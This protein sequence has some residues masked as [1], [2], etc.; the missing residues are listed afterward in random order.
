MILKNSILVFMMWLAVSPA[1]AATDS[2]PIRGRVIDRLSRRPVSFAAVVIAG[3][4]N[5]GASTDSAGLFLIEHVQPGI[6]RLNVSSLGY[7]STVT[8]EYLVSAATPF[9]EIELEEDASQLEAVTVTPSPFRR[10]AESPVS[11]KVIG[12]REIEKSPGSNRDI[13]RIVRSYPGVSFSP[14]GYR[15]DLIVRGGGPSENRFFMDG[16]EIPNINHFATQG[17]SGG[18][19]S[20]VN[21]DLVREINLY[22]GSFPANRAGALSSVLD[23]KLRDGDPKRQTFKATLGA[24]EV[25]ISGSGHI[26][27]KTTYL[28]SLR[29]SY[30]QFLFKLLGLPFLPNYIDGQ[31]KIKTR[32]SE[33][34]EL[35][36]LGLT[37]IDNMRLNTDEKGEEAE[38]LLSYLPR[39]K[40]E[41]FTV[42]ASYRHYAGRHV[43]T[44]TLSHT[45]LNNRNVKYRDNDES[46]EDNLI[47][48]LRAVEQKTTLR[49]ENRSYVGR[50]TLREGV[51]LNYSHY[52]NQTLQRLYTQQAGLSDYRTLLGTVGWGAFV[53]ADYASANKRLTA[54]AGLRADGCDYSG[55]TARF[56]HQLSPRA[57]VSYALSDGW[58]VSGSAGL[59]YQLPPYTA[60]G[61]KNSAGQLVNRDLKYMRVAETSGGFAWRLRDRLIVSLEGFYKFYNDIPL[62]LAD[63][64]PLTCKGNDYGTVGDERLVSTAEGRAYGLEAMVQW[65]I[66]GK[67]NV[68]GSATVYRSEYRNDRRSPYIASA[69]DNRFVLNLSGTYDLPRSW[70]IGAKV[71]AIGG[72]PYTP[73]D[74]EKSSLKVAWDAQGRP[75]YDY[76]RYNSGRLSAFAQLDLRVDKTFYFKNCMLGLYIDLQNVTGSK[77]RQP[78]VLMSTGIVENPSAPVADQRYKMKYIKQ[79]SGTLV[80]TLGVTVEF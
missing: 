27:E 59:Y 60:L 74:V 54:S 33:T 2:Y 42:G 16:I 45:Y 43:Q 76:D 39:L 4:E 20:I 50:W 41:T 77:L 31:I 63:S 71:S 9:I 46:S 24:S 75:Y 47:L 67:L 37:G 51:E 70:S 34:D 25:G 21:S 28:F 1:L 38:Y 36:I 18:P 8:P 61:F 22:T 7:K 58:S 14:V 5:K 23:F 35:T 68:V 44:V 11:M 53:G 13:S 32:L 78:D 3:Q 80:P 79:A 6:Y 52:T 26:G 65:Q 40:Q 73:Y 66:P 30:L 29:Q 49:A 57:S 62:S 55:Q 19:V 15:N 64:I 17:A 56:W 12:L 72:A 69:W 10:T 48:R